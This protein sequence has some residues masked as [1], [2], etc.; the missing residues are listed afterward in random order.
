[1]ITVHAYYNDSQ[2]WDTKIVGKIVG[3]NVLQILNEP[4]VNAIAYGFEKKA[5]SSDNGD[6]ILIFDLGGGTS[7]VAMLN[8][9][10]HKIEVKAVR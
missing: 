4:I 10:K 5:Y 1:M 2:R 6:N 7:D 3:S 9:K 8:I